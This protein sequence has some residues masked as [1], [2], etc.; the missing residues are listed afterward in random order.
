MLTKKDKDVLKRK[1]DNSKVIL[2]GEDARK[3]Y[4]VKLIRAGFLS[5]WIKFDE[6]KT[7]EYNKEAIEYVKNL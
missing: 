3:E 7:T 6:D 1:Y 4:L 2:Y 5:C